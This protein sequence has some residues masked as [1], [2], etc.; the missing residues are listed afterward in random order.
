VNYLI[1]KWLILKKGYNMNGI[2][3]EDEYRAYEKEKLVKLAVRMRDVC[4]QV[5]LYDIAK[6]TGLKW[7]TIN[8][9]RK[10]KSISF[11]ALCRIERYLQSRGIML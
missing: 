2:V 4:R 8:K 7:D 10:G 5:P 9:A 6:G 3:T 1:I 11:R